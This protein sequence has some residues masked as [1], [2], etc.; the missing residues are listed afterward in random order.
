MTALRS[1]SG[2]PAEGRRRSDLP[3]SV[4]GD[5]VTTPRLVLRYTVTGLV[6]LVL[7][8]VVTVF[9][10]RTIG[11]QEAIGDAIRATSLVAEVAA[12]PTLTDGVLA[13]DPTALAALDHAVRTHV[14]RG[15]LV[16]VKIWDASGRIVYSDESRL[17]GDRFAL[18]D[19]ARSALATG[20]P[21]ADISDLGDPE[22]RLEERAVQL[23]EVYER[24]QTPSGTPVLFEAYFSYAGVTAAGRSLW[25]QF[26]PYILGALGLLA[27]L[28][29]PIAV[30]LARRLHR[31]QVQREHLFARAIEATDAERRRIAGDLHDGVVQDLAGVAFSLGAVTRRDAGGPGM[32]EVENAAGRVRHAVRS[33]R[34]LLVEIYPPNLYEEGLEAALSDLLARLAA[35]G[36]ETSLE[37]GVPVPA[38]DVDVIELLYRVGQEGLR[39]VAEHA[40]AQ[41]VEITVRR[42]GAAVVMRVVDDGRGIDPGPLPD[43]PGH[44]GLRALAGLADRLGATLEMESAPGRGTELRLEVPAR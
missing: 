27:L 4:F 29:V 13:G 18:G 23:L 43:R 37:V 5:R 34:S 33:L 9:A 26:A 2:A 40:D 21:V 3:G 36:T 25:L 35:R 44:L 42:E 17:I 14:V 30:S 1:A 32:D 6:V 7:V 12:E 8:A 28:Q 16:R 19:D 39:N 20:T 41:R 38:L 31:T 11:T 22:N 24:L 10:S 15:S